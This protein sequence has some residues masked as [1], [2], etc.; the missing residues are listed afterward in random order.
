M[1]KLLLADDHEVVRKGLWLTI[2][3]EEDMELLAEASNGRAL[4]VLLAN[5]RADVVLLD[6]QMPEMDGLT[7]ARHIAEQYPDTN[8]LILTSFASD[9]QL[10]E[11]MKAGVT[12]YLLKDAS[13]DAL[14]DAIRGAAKGVLPISTHFTAP[15]EIPFTPTIL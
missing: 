8:V 15:L 7:A 4:L 2:E 6:V 5:E 3:A 9:A 12:G 14:V 11:A 1:I 10:H 13:G